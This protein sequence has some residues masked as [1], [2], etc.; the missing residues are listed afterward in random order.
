MWSYGIALI[1]ECL[2]IL[3]L[4][5]RYAGRRKTR[6]KSDMLRFAQ[7]H[8]KTEKFKLDLEEIKH[9]RDLIKELREFFE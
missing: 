8:Y 7:E 5:R 6:I 9:Q 3:E 2:L 1:T 4:L